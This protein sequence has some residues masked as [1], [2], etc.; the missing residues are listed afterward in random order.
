[1]VRAVLDLSSDIE[2]LTQFFLVKHLN[3]VDGINL[4]H[5]L[6]P[7][8]RHSFSPFQD[9]P[10]S[11]AYQPAECGALSWTEIYRVYRALW[12]IQLYYDLSLLSPFIIRCLSNWDD[13]SPFSIGC[14]SDGDGLRHLWSRLRRARLPAW[15][16]DEMKCV[17]DYLREIRLSNKL[18]MRTSAFTI[19]AA[20]H[21]ADD[22][23][24]VLAG[25][26]TV[27]EQRNHLCM[28]GRP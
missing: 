18:L 6:N 1:M 17:L 25:S 4:S 5:L 10:E 16:M 21:Q 11:Y 15:E 7:D 9:H 20:Y 23:N 14:F 13:L 26:R 22:H 12:R 3:R 2:R 27:R 24:A 8:F 28:W 19:K